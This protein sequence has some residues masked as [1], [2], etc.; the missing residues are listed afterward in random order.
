MSH[1]DWLTENI[2]YPLCHEKVLYVLN[3][4]FN[5]LLLSRLILSMKSATVMS[6]GS[7]QRI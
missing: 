7:V 5:H 2:P 1:F 4:I 3:S 6:R